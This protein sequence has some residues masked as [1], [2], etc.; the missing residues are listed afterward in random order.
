[1]LMF[2]DMRERDYKVLPRQHQLNFNESIPLMKKLGKLHAASAIL[3]EK[4]PSIM[5]P[6]IEGSISINPERQDFLVHY[7]NCARTLGLVAENEWGDEWKEISYKLKA[8]ESTI[9]TK[10]CELYIRD[11]NGF[12][13]FNHNDMWVPNMFF[14]MNENHVEDLLLIDYQMPYFGSPGID[15]N[16]LFFGALSEETR[17]KDS[18]KLIRIYYESLKETL[19]AL[20]F[21]KKIP[22]LHEI[23]IEMLKSGFNS[24]LASIC[25]VPL[26]MV[27][28]S[29]DLHMDLLLAKSEA[30]ERFRYS[31]FNNQKYKN[32]IQKLLI[33]FD[34]LGYLD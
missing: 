10:A 30:A 4:N 31:L 7:K 22:S 3:Y 18:K 6:Y 8:L 15:L 20:K 14:K 19:G 1:M 25:E 12:S 11:P 27:E 13:V 17:L 16:F 9:L 21:N 32:F 24:L 28:H 29:D 5:E 2:E 33:E 34:E 23:H 26:L